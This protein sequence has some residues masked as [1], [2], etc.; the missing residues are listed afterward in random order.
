MPLNMGCRFAAS[1]LVDILF[2]RM[3]NLVGGRIDVNDLQYVDIDGDDFAKFRLRRGDLLFNR[4][5]SFE[6]VGKTSIFDID[7]DFVFAS[8][9]IRVAAYGGPT[10]TPF[11]ELLPQPSDNP[12]RTEDA[13][14]SRSEPIQYQC[15]ETEEH[16]V[17]VPL[18]D[19]QKNAC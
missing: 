13:G 16:Q 8:Y 9:L 12:G 14:H 1:R 5:N 17:S 2:L 19:E 6:L 11:P 7:E 10:A 3:N 4:T 18:I 15:H